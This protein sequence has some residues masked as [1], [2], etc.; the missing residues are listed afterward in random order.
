MKIVTQS[1]MTTGSTTTIHSYEANPKHWQSSESELVPAFPVIKE[2]KT[3]WGKIG[4]LKIN[5]VF[6]LS[7]FLSVQ[8]SIPKPGRKYDSSSELATSSTC[9]SFPLS[10]QT[11][12]FLVSRFPT[13]PPQ[14]RNLA[15]DHWGTT[16]IKV[17]SYN[18]STQPRFSTRCLYK[19]SDIPIFLSLGRFHSWSSNTHSGYT[20]LVHSSGLAHTQWAQLGTLSPWKMPGK[21]AQ[22]HGQNEPSQQLQAA[23]ARQCSL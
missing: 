3:E 2:H 23:E 14:Q 4:K 21:H 18:Y 10:K 6:A 15:Q 19:L 11:P 20:N 7:F 13:G 22:F 1:Y 8:L 9:N 17:F 5:C 12:H 16:W